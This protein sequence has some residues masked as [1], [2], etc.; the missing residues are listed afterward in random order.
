M[1]G[2]FA[3][4]GTGGGGTPD[5][6]LSG[7]ALRQIL[8]GES[9]DEGVIPFGS[10]PGGLLKVTESSPQ[11]RSV[12]VAPGSCIVNDATG[13]ATYVNITSSETLSVPASP[14]GTDI[15]VVYSDGTL[16]YISGN[17]VPNN[18]MLLATI[19]T[20][21]SANITNAEITDERTWF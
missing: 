20:P 16:G 21:A 9:N 10:N 7:E 3:T 2:S 4:M 17:T 6:T 8:G 19:A 14:T 15:V 13:A 11:D 18:A 12:D 1:P 5:G